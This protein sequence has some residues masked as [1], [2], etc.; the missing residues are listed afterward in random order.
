MVQKGA[1][2]VS[3]MMN[4]NDTLERRGWVYTVWRNC[5]AQKVNLE[6]RFLQKRATAEDDCTDIEDLFMTKDTKMKCISPIP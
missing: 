5:A 4:R 3:P 1:R 2:V 6:L